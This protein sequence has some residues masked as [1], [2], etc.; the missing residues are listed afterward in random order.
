MVSTKGLQSGIVSM[1]YIYIDIFIYL[2]ISVIICL[3]IS[4]K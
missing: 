3:Y 4:I 2:N 1:Y